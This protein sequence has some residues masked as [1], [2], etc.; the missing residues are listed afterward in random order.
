MSDS[1]DEGNSFELI[2]EECYYD[3]KYLEKNLKEDM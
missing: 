2:E 3:D 1:E